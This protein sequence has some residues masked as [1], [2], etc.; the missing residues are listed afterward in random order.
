MYKTE[1]KQLKPFNNTTCAI[2][3]AKAEPVSYT[4]SRISLIKSRGSSQIL[5]WPTSGPQPTG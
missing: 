5:P 1:I 4:I 2:I 3:S